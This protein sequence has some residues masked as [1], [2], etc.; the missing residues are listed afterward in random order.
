MKA[1]TIGMALAATV[2]AGTVPLLAQTLPFTVQSGKPTPVFNYFN[3]TTHFVPSGSAS[4]SHGTV[5]TERST[6]EHCG[7]PAEPVLVFV[8]TSDPGYKGPE[9]INFFLPG[10]Q[11]QSITIQVR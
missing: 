11:N 2:I 6:R 3:C 7:N 10:G 9:G 8:Y 5:T 1:V 4:A